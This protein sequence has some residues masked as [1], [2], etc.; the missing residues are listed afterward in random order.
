M[1]QGSSAPDDKR[2]VHVRRIMD[3]GVEEGVF[4]GAVA[5]L[6]SNG[7]VVFAHAVGQTQVAPEPCGPMP[8]DALF[9]LASVTKPLSGIALMLCIEDGLLNLDDPVGRYIPEFAQGDKAIIRIRHIVSH[10]SGVQSNPRL[11]NEY[12]TWEKLK[13]A[14]LALPLIGAPGS[15]FLYSSINF[16]LLALIIERVTGRTLDGLLNERV[17]GPMGL[18]ITYNPPESLK[19]RIP[20]T[21]YVEA[22]GEYDWGIVGDK[23]AQK[24]GGVSAHAGLFGTAADLT[25]L[26]S[27]LLGGGTHKGVRVMSPAAARLFTSRW[28]DERGAQRG[29]CWLPASPKVYGDLL[30]PQALGHTG[31]TGTAMCL[32]PGDRLVAVLLTNRVNPTRDNDRI[33]AFRP[34]FFNALTAALSA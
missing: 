16:I 22:R 27:M 7:E 14:Y 13:P 1:E 20:A 9:D 8:V 10:T 19:H 12:K 4:P 29:I 17:F 25:A 26:G 31:H 33:E 30:S 24:M 34:L 3:K 23:T 5:A 21:E 28:T 15:L 11:Q 18:T 2:L 6:A 32:V